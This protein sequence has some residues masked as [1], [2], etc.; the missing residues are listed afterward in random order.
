[1]KSISLEKSLAVHSSIP[2][3]FLPDPIWDVDGRWFD[4]APAL[5]RR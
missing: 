2:S 1:M 4:P 3:V 5:T